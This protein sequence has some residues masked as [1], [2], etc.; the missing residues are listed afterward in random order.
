MVSGWTTQRYSSA[1]RSQF[2]ADQALNG[3]SRQRLEMVILGTRSCPDPLEET[4]HR[5]LVSH[6]RISRDFGRMLQLVCEERNPIVLSQVRV[7]L[8]AQHPFPSGSRNQPGRS[9]PDTGF[10]QSVEKHQHLR[11]IEPT[12][13][14][15]HRP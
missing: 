4:K 14:A 15:F 11:V 6:G 12:D 13:E 7:D 2:L 5:L 8:D 10:I 9:R 1:V 3:L